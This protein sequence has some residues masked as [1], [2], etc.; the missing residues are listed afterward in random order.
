MC[1]GRG[2]SVAPRLLSTVDILQCEQVEVSFPQTAELKLLTQT[3]CAATC[4][5][6]NHLVSIHVGVM[7]L[8]T[9]YSFWFG[10]D[11]CEWIQKYTS[12]SNAAFSLSYSYCHADFFFFCFNLQPHR[13]LL[14]PYKRC[15]PHVSPRLLQPVCSLQHC[16]C[17]NVGLKL[18]AYMNQVLFHYPLPPIHIHFTLTSPFSSQW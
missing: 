3:G 12:T 13:V 2:H 5:Q 1:S 18:R 9:R 4:L 8:R 6:R 14:W 11:S 7:C 17:I 15:Y 10:K 16:C